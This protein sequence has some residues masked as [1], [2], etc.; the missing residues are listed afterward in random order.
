MAMETHLLEL[1]RKHQALEKEIEEA[2]HHPGI[3]TLALTELK[4]KK[5]SLKDE[6]ERLRTTES[7]H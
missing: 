7:V 3:D 5:L 1:E 2:M 6:I 4:R